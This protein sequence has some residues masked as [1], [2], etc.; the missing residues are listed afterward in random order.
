M[1]FVFNNVVAD[2][3]VY[4]E[5]LALICGI[6]DWCDLEK[7]SRCGVCARVGVSGLLIYLVKCGG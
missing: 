3:T 7:V 6:V 4:R 2:L 5:E 1:R